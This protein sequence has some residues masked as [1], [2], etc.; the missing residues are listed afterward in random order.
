[1]SFRMI[2]APADRSPK[3][4]L[5]VFVPGNPRREKGFAEVVAA[6]EILR[7]SGSSAAFHFVVQRPR[8]RSGVRG[9]YS[10]RPAIRRR[11]RVD[12]LSA[13]RQGIHRQARCS[14]MVILPYHLDCYELRTSG[15]FARRALRETGHRPRNS[16]AG[17]RIA[18][19]GGR[20]AGGRARCCGVGLGPEV[21]A[22]AV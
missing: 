8:A 3:Q 18:R 17:D 19:E 22:R 16:W 9:Y 11:D 21:G 12:R 14:D 4:P 6:I 13:I 15:F 10:T 7:S 20:V 1:M 5:V 2:S